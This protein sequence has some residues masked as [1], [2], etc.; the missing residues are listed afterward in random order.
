[1]TLWGGRKATEQVVV[2]VVFLTL[3][4]IILSLRL[5][6]RVIVTRNHGPE[7]WFVTVAFVCLADSINLDRK[8]DANS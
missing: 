8:Q 1:M 3:A 5:Y 4:L 7:D 2:V 6:T